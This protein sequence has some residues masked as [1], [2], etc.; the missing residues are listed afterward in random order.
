MSAEFDRLVAEF[1]KFKSKI[2]QLDSTFST[3]DEMQ[4]E[5]RS[6]EV[7]ATA[8]DR[9][10]TVTAGPGGSVTDLKLS[11][12]A[13]RQQPASL[14]AT[15]MAT[16]QQ[17]VA[18]SARE[19]AGIVAAHMASSAPF[20][21]A[22]QLLDAQSQALGTSKEDLRSQMGDSPTTGSRGSAARQPELDDEDVGRRSFAGSAE[23]TVPES[24]RGGSAGDA[25][26]R[27]LLNDEE[28][29]R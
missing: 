25:F 19:E 10:V 18:E 12:E 8:P 27:S 9:S 5:V 2:Q 7:S 26:L 11:N 14:A 3:V 16:L 1:D 15:I 24:E 4:E 23:S 20:G 22:D 17:A 29:R 6:L 28:D 13:M 21:S